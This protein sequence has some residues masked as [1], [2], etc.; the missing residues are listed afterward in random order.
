MDHQIKTMIVDALMKIVDSAPTKNPYQQYVTEQLWQT[1]NPYQANKIQ[2]STVSK[3]SFDIWMNYIFSVLKITEQYIDSGLYLSVCNQ[4]QSVALHA[5]IDYTKKTYE[6]CR[7]L[8][9]FAR[10]ILYL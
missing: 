6:I 7:I 2:R 1:Q 5:D 10:K 8:L 3:D 9:E 4:I